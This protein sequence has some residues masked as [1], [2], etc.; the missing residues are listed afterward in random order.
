L[1][2]LGALLNLQV[3]DRD[4]CGP[5]IHR[6][7]QALLPHLLRLVGQRGDE[8]HA[9]VLQPLTGRDD[10]DRL[11]HV[12]EP[13]RAA[14]GPQQF[15]LERLHAERDA[16]DAGAHELPEPSGVERAGVHLDGHLGALRHSEPAAQR[17]E[18]RRHEPRRDQRRRAAAEED[19]LER[20]GVVVG[21]GAG[22]GDLA[23]QEA[24]VVG[25]PRVLCAL[26]A[27]GRGRG[28]GAERD[29]GEVAVV[30]ALAAEGEVDVGGGRRER[31]QRQ[32]NGRVRRGGGGSGISANRWWAWA[33]WGRLLWWEVGD[34]REGGSP[35]YGVSVN[36][37]PY[38]WTR[39]GCG[40]DK[41]L[42]E[43]IAG[44]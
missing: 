9:P 32:G 42:S 29:D 17:V 22:G 26:A 16:V 36:R 31:W 25:D 44:P 7:P 20:D 15:L 14:A 28:G 12:P 38:G 40:K 3:I 24:H 27:R 5:G 34:E 21:D 8:V 23:Q 10:L 41:Y 18:H 1:T 19:G 2:K 6:A 43:S 39:S 35:H 13:V 30:A 11:V 4:V 33:D 37:R